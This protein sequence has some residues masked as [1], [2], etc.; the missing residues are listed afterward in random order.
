MDASDTTI[1][2]SLGQKQN[3]LSYAIYFIIR[4]LTPTKLNYIVMKK[5]FIVVVHAINKFKHYVT[6]YEIFVH[7]DQFSISYLMNKPIMNGRITIWLL[8]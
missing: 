2:T 7:I 4:S 6:G 5:V 3:H 1:G 8:L